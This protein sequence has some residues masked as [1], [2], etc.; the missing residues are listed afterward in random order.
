MIDGH[1]H[2]AQWEDEQGR[3]V[4][5]NLRNY[6]QE[7]GIIAV[8][9][10]CCS[11]NGKLWKGFEADQSILG[12]VA[13]LENETVFTHG[14]LYIPEDPGQRAA[15][16]FRD[17]LDELMELGM[18]GIKICDFKPDAYRL[19]QVEEHLEEYDAFIG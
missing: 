10:M 19:Y 5:E 7:N 1:M 17:Q 11:N 2:I 4:F 16:P 13:K 12:A 9:N 8:D 6:Q 3:S 18:D 15:F 14:C